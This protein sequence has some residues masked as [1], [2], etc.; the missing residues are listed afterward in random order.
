MRNSP[1]HFLTSTAIEM[2][3]LGLLNC[4]D[5]YGYKIAKTVDLQISEST[6]YPTLRRLEYGGYLES[7]SQQH[8]AKLR[9]V[10][11]IT[12]NGKTRLAELKDCWKQVVVCV[13]SLLDIGCADDTANREIK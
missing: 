7:Y 8:N 10:Y 5:A 4:N 2:C 6:I 11:K 12:P 3:V 9:K 13:D 1:K